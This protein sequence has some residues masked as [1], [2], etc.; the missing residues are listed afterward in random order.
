MFLP[1]E[2]LLVFHR[3][4]FV[5]LLLPLLRL[6]SLIVWMSGQI[7]RLCLDGFLLFLIGGSEMSL[8][9]V[10]LSVSCV[11]FYLYPSLLCVWFQLLLF[12]DLYRIHFQI[13]FYFVFS[14]GICLAV[15]TNIAF[16]L[17]RGFHDELIISSSTV[18]ERVDL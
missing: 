18:V 1:L 5:F 6:L 2:Y 3:S 17:S 9:M 4:R 16:Q 10:Y 13:C 12:V 7:F 8:V 11:L 15:I 14:L